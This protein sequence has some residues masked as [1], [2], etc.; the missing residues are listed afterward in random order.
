MN[1]V[2]NLFKYK[3]KLYNNGYNIIQ[4]SGKRKASTVNKEV[5][6]FLKFLEHFFYFDRNM[7]IPKFSNLTGRDIYIEIVF[8]M[9]TVF[10]FS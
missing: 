3:F 5:H 4:Y 1:L 10:H 8:C 7:Q 2:E 9:V 6:F